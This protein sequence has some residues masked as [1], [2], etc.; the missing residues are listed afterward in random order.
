[1][2]RI[3]KPKLLDKPLLRRSLSLVKNKYLV[4]TVLML[5]WMLFFDRYSLQTRIT[6]TRKRNKMIEDRDYYKAKADE[7]RKT[8]SDL[9]SSPA[10]LEKFAREKYYMKKD[11]ED[12]F[13][14]ER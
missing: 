14:V 3:R 10:Q 12:V 2:N 11:S 8:Y 4:F 7:A 1:M 9:F 6:D 5:T 13:I